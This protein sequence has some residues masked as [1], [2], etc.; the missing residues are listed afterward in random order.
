[1]SS[2]AAHPDAVSVPSLVL[3]T[4]VV[5]DW[6]VFRNPVSAGL[7]D[8]IE[9]GRSRWLVSTD[10]RN[11]LAHV[12]GR[13]VGASFS[14]D[15]TALWATWDRLAIAVE[16]RIPSGAGCRLRCTDPDDQKFIDLALAHGARWLLT[17]D[18]AVLKLARRCLP[19]GLQV[20]A[21]E[22]WLESLSAR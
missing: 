8:H 4:N 10:I 22:R 5:L 12:L 1:M 16:P 14:P 19:L 21:P 20:L 18:R 9:A 13:G 3:D 2:T 6:L 11:E 17:R 15:M 7:A